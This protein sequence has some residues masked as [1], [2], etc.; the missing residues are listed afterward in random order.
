MRITIPHTFMNTHVYKYTH[1]TL[2][3]DYNN[4]SVVSGEVI[5]CPDTDYTFCTLYEMAFLISKTDKSK[6]I[7][8]F[9]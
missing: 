2:E 5:K 6:L 8:I 9:I 1:I 7:Y 3:N 4:E